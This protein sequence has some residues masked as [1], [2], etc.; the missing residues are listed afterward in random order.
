[1]ADF[2]CYCF[3]HTAADIRADVSAHGGRSE[4][5]E[6]IV[7]AKKQ[8]TC[9]CTEKHP[10]RRCCLGDVRRVVDAARTEMNNGK[11]ADGDNK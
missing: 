6:K 11:E 8:R 2:I 1:M 10:E 3:E 5:L 7:A 4:V 9:R